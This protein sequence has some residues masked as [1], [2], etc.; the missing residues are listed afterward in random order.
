M[1]EYAAKLLR[2]EPR[3]YG[4]KAF[5][6]RVPFS[7]K[8]MYDEE[9][10]FVRAALEDGETGTTGKHIDILEEGIAAFVGTKYG[11]A[12]SSQTAA[13]HMAVKL[14]AE[15]LYG[16]SSGITTPDGSRKGGVL[17]GKRVFCPDFAPASI[18][19]PVIYE[20]GEPIFVDMDRNDWGMDPEVLQLAFGQYPSV[21]IVI[22][23]HPYGFPGTVEEIRRICDEH[24]ALL[25]EDASEC[26]GATV[27]G[28]QVGGFGDYGI[29]GF[30]DESIIPVGTGSMLLVRDDYSA[31]KA[32]Y[33]VAG[34]HAD[35]KWCQHEELGYECGMDNV[36]A[37]IIRGQMIHLEEHLKRKKE[38]YKYY[39]EKLDG[40]MVPMNPD[41][42]DAKPNYAVSCI[43]SESGIQFREMRS[44]RKYQ[45]ISQHGTASPMEIFEVLDAFGAECRV[46]WKPLSMQPMF[47]NCEQITLDGGRRT[48]E[49]FYRDS[50]F[51]RCNESKYVFGNG[52]CLPSGISM[53]AEEQDRIVDIIHDCF[54]A[55]DFEKAAW[56][57]AEER[58][59]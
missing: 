31:E 20:G 3:F 26:L 34:S 24:G 46:P 51:Q 13:V 22:M 57:Q 50:F 9:M 49:S 55:P 10:D 52:L 48:Y 39:G 25:I 6:K 29:V 16:A 35:A 27:K 17:C 56:T 5:A 41:G 23:Y 14:A 45:Y 4:N 44:E 42:E 53:T 59:A 54:C 7:S 43:L 1:T 40:N 28:K 8:V 30:S 47:R 18:V 15:R 19:N 33:W 38:I 21:N 37:G 11:V 36:T 2:E 32:R 58:T 12:L